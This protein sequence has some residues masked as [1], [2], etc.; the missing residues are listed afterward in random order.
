VTPKIFPHLAEGPG[1]GSNRPGEWPAEKELTV[2]KITDVPLPPGAVFADIWKGHD[3]ERVVS[4]PRRGITDADV[5]VWTTS[6]QRADGR[7]STE[8]E[9]PLVHISR[10]VELNSD[11]AR[12]LAAL[13]LEI[14]A[15]MDRWTR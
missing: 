14:A 5:V 13:L 15:Q 2:S 12:E 11:Q 6:I 1:D 3:P 8:P 10:G 4:G 9:P 7:I